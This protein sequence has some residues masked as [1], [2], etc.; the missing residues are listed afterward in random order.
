MTN[1]LLQDKASELR[2]RATT[3]SQAI[4]M[5]DN[6]E[7]DLAPEVNRVE[8]SEA[9]LPGVSG[10]TFCGHAVFG[11]NGDV[12]TVGVRQNCKDCVDLMIRREGST[13]RVTERRYLQGRSLILTVT[14][15]FGMGGA[16]VSYEEI[17]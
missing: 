12:M 7:L 16:L 5:L 13:T 15:V 8:L 3:I 11:G 6:S 14:A 1:T 2:Q 17:F 10:G 9:R 4:Q